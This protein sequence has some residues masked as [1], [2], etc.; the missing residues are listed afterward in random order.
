MKSSAKDYKIKRLREYVN[1]LEDQIEH[2]MHNITMPTIKEFDF[3]GCARTPAY[4]YS[5]FMYLTMFRDEEVNSPEFYVGEFVTETE[6][7]KLIDSCRADIRE[8]LDAVPFR[9]AK[10]RK[11]FREY[12]NALLLLIEDMEDWLQ[13]NMQLNHALATP[14]VKFE[15]EAFKANVQ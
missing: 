4:Y 6:V 15:E 9:G 10:Q 11:V 7:I 3:G 5:V 12:K 2:C 1:S 14:A 13:A 8:A